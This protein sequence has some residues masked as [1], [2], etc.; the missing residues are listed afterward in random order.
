MPRITESPDFAIRPISPAEWRSVA[1]GGLALP[2]GF[3]EGPGADLEAERVTPLAAFSN[4]RALGYIGV[5]QVTREKMTPQMD[6]ALKEL[7]A[8]ARET[9]ELDPAAL[10]ALEQPD[11]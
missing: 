5:R 1:V 6:T 4:E 11:T 10:A 8:K 2:P 9:G 3:W 7:L